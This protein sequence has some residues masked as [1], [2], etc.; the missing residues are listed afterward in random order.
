MSSLYFAHVYPEEVRGLVLTG[1][2]TDDEDVWKQVTMSTFLT[3]AELAEKEGMQ[4]AIDSGGGY[5]EWREQIERI[6]QKENELLSMD[7]FIF[8][9]TMRAW[10]QSFTKHG[11]GRFAGLSDQELSSIESPAIV[12]SGPDVGAGVHP[13]HTAKELDEKLPNSVLVLS[14]EY[15][16]DVWD[17]ILEQ[18]E[19][20]GG[21]YYDASFADRIDEFI[22]SVR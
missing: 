11:R 17:D 7:P 9:R 12:F 20:K 15:Y 3:P 16:A 22:R 2:P 18:V 4:A 6:P 10:A 13:Q 14:P 1:P 21:E 5:F 8:A 19:E